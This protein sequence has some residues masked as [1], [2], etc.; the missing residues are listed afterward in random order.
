MSEKAPRYLRSLASQAVL[1]RL[2]GEFPADYRRVF[3]AY[4]DSRNPTQAASLELRRRHPERAAEIYAE[5]VVA[6]GL[7]APRMKEEPD[8]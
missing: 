1:R 8:A 3:P 5:E 2:R 4:R 6:R 7:P